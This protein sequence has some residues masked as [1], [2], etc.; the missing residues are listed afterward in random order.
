LVTS[1]TIIEDIEDMC[2]A[3]LAS[4]AYFYFDVRDTAKQDIRGLLTSLLVQLSARSDLYCKTLS[5]LYYEHDSG[6]QQPSGDVLT[7]GLKD[8]LT[9]PKQGP[10]YIIM[11]AVDEC[12]NKSGTSSPRESVLGLLNELVQLNHPDL[13]ICV[14]SRP[15]PDIETTL[16]PLSS[17]SMSLHGKTGK[18]QDDIFDYVSAVVNSDQRM[19]KW[20][21][22]DQRLVIDTLSEKADGMY[23]IVISSS[24]INPCSSA[25]CR[26]R[27]V[28]CQLDVLRLSPPKSIRRVLEELPK[29]LG[30]TYEN[31]LERIDEENWEYAHRLFQCITVASRPL[32]V[33]ELAELLAFDFSGGQRSVPKFVEDRRPKNPR[34]AMLSICSSLIAVTEVAGARVVQFSHFSFGEFLTSSRLA[35]ARGSV[36]RYIISLESA[37]MTV[38]QACLGLL[39]QL[40]HVDRQKIDGWPLAKYAARYWVSHAQFGNV[41]ESSIQR[42]MESLFD[43]NKP[44]FTVW[45]S[46]WDVD[47]E[48]SAYRPRDA[49]PKPTATALYYAALCGLRDVVKWLIMSHPQD[50]NAIGGNHLTPLHATSV[51]G[52]LKVALLLLEHGADVNYAGHYGRTPLHLAVWKNHSEMATLLLEHGANANAQDLQQLTPLYYAAHEGQLEV[53]RVLLGHGANVGARNKNAETA[54]HLAVWNNHLEMVTLLLEHGADVNSQDMQ[55]LTPLYY[56]A[57]KGRLEVTRVLL[58]HGADVQTQNKDGE[59]A[60]HLAVWQHDLAMATLL[61]VNG[62]NANAQDMQQLTPLH[63]VAHKGKPEV[64]RVLLRH[65]ADV[66]ARNKDGET[67]LHLAARRNHLAMATLLLE[68]GADVNAR[69]NE[70]RSV[71][72]SALQRGH[73]DVVN[74][75]SKHEATG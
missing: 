5:T 39:L 49:S 52:Y 72:D 3:G 26:F 56:A 8:M 25:P 48:W 41:S 66:G 16:R 9:I 58:R 2:E 37:H 62:T 40:D 73:K 31:A 63:R 54:L 53:M 69:D 71:L 61:L 6:L 59:T 15:E 60:L 57:Q 13:H 55:Q 33:E 42:A 28:S 18:I 70:G 22:E 24:V 74:L 32:R 1:S 20:T 19:Q 68:H 51:R 38:T 14:T 7:Q 23:V 10:I 11:D 36:S 45:V 75:L 30:A 27:W 64:A 50:I 4:L 17:Q 47:E 21:A 44:H 34:V 29:A 43:P 46:I 35:M 65:G 67:A 12:P